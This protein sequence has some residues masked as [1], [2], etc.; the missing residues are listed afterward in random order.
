M[1]SSGINKFLILGFFSQDIFLII[2]LLI[3]LTTYPSI[4]S[5]NSHCVPTTTMSSTYEDTAMNKFDNLCSQVV[6]IPWRQSTADK[7]NKKEVEDAH[8]M[9]S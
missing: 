4:Y 9:M 7:K 1:R 3:H 8:T 5:S 6:C 2:Y